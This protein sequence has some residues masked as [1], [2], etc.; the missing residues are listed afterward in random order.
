ML[1]TGIFKLLF[2][3]S[4]ITGIRI[5]ALGVIEGYRKLGIEAC[6][7]GTIIKEYK[8]KGY[9]TADAGWTLE[10]NDMINK[11]ILAIKG[12][13]YKTFRIYEKVI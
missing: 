9:T 12:D 7:Y 3:K 2:N 11:A 13:P 4:K 1:P 8:R 6:L 5:Y 10:N